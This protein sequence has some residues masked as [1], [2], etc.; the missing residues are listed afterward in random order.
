VSASEAEKHMQNCRYSRDE[1]NTKE[2]K[3]KRTMSVRL[4]KSQIGINDP[5]IAVAEK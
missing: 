5:E 4:I 3:K 2:S 1:C